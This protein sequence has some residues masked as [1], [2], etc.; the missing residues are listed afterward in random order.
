MKNGSADRFYF[1]VFF[2]LLLWHCPCFMT[3]P[4]F[5]GIACILWHCRCNE[6]IR[7]S[8]VIAKLQ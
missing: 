7:Y 1:F 2:F 8:N 5:Y 4:A 3:L 6:I